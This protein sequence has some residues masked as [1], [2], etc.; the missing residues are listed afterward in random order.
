MAMLIY[1]NV[2][3]RLGDGWLWRKGEASEWQLEKLPRL[4]CSHCRE[5]VREGWSLC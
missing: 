2:K 5:L 1:G 4:R 3:T